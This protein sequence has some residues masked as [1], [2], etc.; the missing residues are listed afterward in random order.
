MD[1]GHDPKELDEA[2]A[3]EH[4]YA[5][6]RIF[7]DLALVLCDFCQVDFGSY[8]P[9][10]FGLPLGKSVGMQRGWQFVRDVPAS[11]EKGKCCPECNRRLPFLEFMVAARERH[12]GK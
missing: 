3:G 8:D 4:T 1:C 6:Y 5:E 7:G 2:R 10:I 12:M 11:I 9:T